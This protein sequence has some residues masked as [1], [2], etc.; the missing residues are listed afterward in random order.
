[1][2]SYVLLGTIFYCLY[3]YIVYPVV[4]KQREDQLKKLGEQLLR[5]FVPGEKLTAFNLY[6]RLTER[7]GGKCAPMV[8]IYK[9]LESLVAEGRLVLETTILVVGNESLEKREYSLPF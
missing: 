3:R 9:P 4:K 8:L 2:F 7:T 6:K 5:L 1:M